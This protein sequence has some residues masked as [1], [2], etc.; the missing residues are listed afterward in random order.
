MATTQISLLQL[1]NY[2]PWTVTPVPRREMDLQ[3]M[4]SRLYADVAQFIGTCGGYASSSRFD[5]MIAVT[6]GLDSDDLAALQESI[7]NRYSVTVS[8]STAV[9]S[10]PLEALS[11][12]TTTL[13][14]LGSAQDPERTELL[15]GTTLSSQDRAPSPT[16]KLGISTST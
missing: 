8:I 9:G 6:N 15:C 3:A 1:N 16:S 11:Q 5:N 4:Q 10:S 13:Q 12:A 2:G 14:K 7:A